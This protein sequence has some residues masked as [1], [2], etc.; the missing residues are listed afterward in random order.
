MRDRTAV[1]DDSRRRETRWDDPGVQR[2]EPD[3]EDDLHRRFLSEF[4]TAREAA[5]LSYS[6]LAARTRI[7]RSTLFRWASGHGTPDFESLTRL[8]DALGAQGR[9]Q[10]LGSTAAAGVWDPWA[11]PGIAAAGEHEHHWPARYQGL[12]WV[13]LN[14]TANRAGQSH[15][16]EMQ[17]G[18]NRLSLDEILPAGGIYLT[19]GKA[20]EE[21]AV[22]LTVRT[23]PH[24]WSAFGSGQPS[25]G[26]P[27]R[28]I[29][30]NW[31]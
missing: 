29:R 19:T 16:V 27:A 28:D 9:L 15:H 13:L 22:I 30:S 2:D 10:A 31:S 17:W 4:A 8:D 12:V 23:A 26:R 14:P 25:D 6:D 7:P 5:R 11:H 20:S 3:E 1:G 21:H 18:P 24:T